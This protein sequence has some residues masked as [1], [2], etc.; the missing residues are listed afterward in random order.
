MSALPHLI[1]GGSAYGAPQRLLRL[2]NLAILAGA[3]AC[4]TWLQASWWLFALLILVPD[5][6]MVGYIHSPRSGAAIYNAG[7]WYGLP[8]VMG[9]IGV[10]RHDDTMI[11]IALIWVAHIAFDRMLGFG[12]KYPKGFKVTHLGSGA[13][14]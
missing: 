2:E 8:A 7:H 12:L 3:I 1:S 5:A 14:A 11:A 9:A 4:Y 10:I 13:G 6:T